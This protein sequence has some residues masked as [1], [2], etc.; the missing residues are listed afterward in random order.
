MTS[1]SLLASLRAAVAAAPE[2]VALRA[3]L[4]EMLAAAGLSTEAIREA[5]GVLQRDPGHAA[6]AELIGRAS[7]SDS[8]VRPSPARPAETDEL[9]ALEAQLEGVVPPMFADVDEAADT[10]VYDAEEPVVRLADVG[11]LSDVKARLEAAFLAPLRHPE[12]GRLYKKSVAGGLLLYGP[13]GCGKTFIARALAGEI[14]ARFV[15]VSLADVLD[16]WVGASERNVHDIFELARRQAPCIVFL[17]EVDALGQ[18]RS[19]MRG[20]AARGAVTQL[21]TE[22]DGL[23]GAN[24]GVYVLGA[25]NHPWDVDVALRR[26]GRFDRV[27]LVVPP[28]ADARA[29]ILRSHLRDR[30]IE[31]IDA[32]KLAQ[33]TDGFSGADLAYVCNVAAERALLDSARSGAVRMIEQHDMEAAVKDVKPS[34]GA[35]LEIAKNVTQ[36]ANSDGSYDELRDYLRKRRMT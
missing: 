1:D 27:V 25:T 28:D 8:S 24:A 30:P 9:R 22:M 35:W 33:Q 7:L 16:M 13:P 11:G 29:A 2:D 31:N 15:S 36:F 23:E 6:A 26:P 3:H 20:S 19:Q 10:P 32:R 21:L 4:A 34:I 18:K 14:G 5:A 17:D 12:L